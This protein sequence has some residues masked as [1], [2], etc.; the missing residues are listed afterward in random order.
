MVTPVAYTLS[1]VTKHSYDTTKIGITVPVEP[2]YGRGSI[3]Q[4]RLCLIEDDAELYTSKFD[5]D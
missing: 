1:F 3:D 4:L 5:D 2:A